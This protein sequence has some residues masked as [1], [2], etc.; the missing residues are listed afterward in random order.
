MIEKPV[1]AQYV[2]YAEWKQGSLDEDK[3]RNTAFEAVTDRMIIGSPADCIKQIHTYQRLGIDSL[4][5]VFQQ[6]GIPHA[7]TL[8]C[9]RRFAL[10]VTPH[11]A[12]QAAI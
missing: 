1:M 4:L 2:A 11:F 5:M 12:P 3:Y 9:M 7:E 6:P 10:E 8:A